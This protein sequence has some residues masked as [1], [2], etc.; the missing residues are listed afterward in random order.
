MRSYRNL[1]FIL[2][3]LSGY[4]NDGHSRL[5]KNYVFLEEE[6]NK[7][8]AAFAGRPAKVTRARNIT[9]RI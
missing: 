6:C 3:K 9:I 2:R 1:K 4:F 5:I 7:N 8:I